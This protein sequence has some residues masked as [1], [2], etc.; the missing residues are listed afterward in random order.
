MNPI[1][2]IGLALIV[3]GVALGYMGYQESESVASQVSEAVT[4]TG[5]DR[6]MM[7]MIGGAIS[8]VVGLVLGVKK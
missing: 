3:L 7:L 4:G 6:S 1:R 2:I 8:L 5:T